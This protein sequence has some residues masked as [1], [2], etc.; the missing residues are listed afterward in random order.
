MVFSAVDFED[1]TVATGIDQS[2]TCTISGLSQDTPVTWIDP[3]NNE[4]SNTDTNN[5]VIDQGTYVF[6]SKAS[7]LEIKQ[8]KLENLS[9][10]SIFKCKLKTA[11]YP[12]YSPD[13]VKEMTL[14]LIGLSMNITILYSSSISL[15]HD[16]KN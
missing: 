1:R 9:S 5:Y 14:T 15:F 8:S 16:N 11:R 10:P 6:G 3:D 4:I 7:T 2:L 13:V 12:T